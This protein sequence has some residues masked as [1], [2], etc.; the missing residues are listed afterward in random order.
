MNLGCSYPT[1][2]FEAIQSAKVE[3]VKVEFPHRPL[4]H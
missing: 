3:G 1:L 2:D 4:V